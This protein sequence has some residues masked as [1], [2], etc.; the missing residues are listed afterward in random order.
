MI[1]VCPGCG[2]T[3]QFKDKN[4]IGYSPKKDAKFCERCFKLKNYNVKEVVDLK[5]TNEDIIN[6]IS[7]KEGAIFFITDF[8]NISNKVINTYKKI[9]HHN[10]Y[11]LIN[12]VDYIPKSIS[13]NNYIDY[14][15][16][17]YN[18]NGNVILISALNKYHLNE[19]I[20]LITSYKNSYICGYTNSGKSTIINE[21][22][23]S[24]G[25]KS[26]ILTSLMPNTTLDLIK[27]RLDEN[28]HIY[29]TPG[30]VNDFEFDIN[31]FPKKFIKPITIQTKP[32]DIL[33]LGSGIYIK[34]DDESNSF[35]FYVSDLIKV[36]KVYDEEVS[37]TNRF[38]IE[39]NSDLVI[40]GY[41]FINI[42]NKCQILI[43]TNNCEIRK[44][45][46]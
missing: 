44:S 11:L 21:I 26:N 38:D 25:K 20:N 7:N 18:V 19:L 45:Y 43:N 4:S 17:T 5:Y 41:G 14:I 9:N 16:S 8:L 33:K 42:K 15:K 1:K 27:I 2:S 35:T 37:I 29:D 12:K 3:L 40:Y 23:N 6:L 31:S 28:I 34:C 10:K 30:F 13:K 24:F 32:N 39:E 22:C 36:K 46:F